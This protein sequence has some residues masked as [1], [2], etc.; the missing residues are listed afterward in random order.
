MAGIRAWKTCLHPGCTALTK[1]GTRCAKHAQQHKSR[2]QAER[3]AGEVM[4]AYR[5]ARWMRM[6]TFLR[7]RNPL[8]QRLVNGQQCEQ[9]STILHH[10]VSPRERPDLMFSAENL[11]CVCDEHHPSTAGE[12]DPSRYVPTVTD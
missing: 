12:T 4:K 8:C 2:Q 7:S 10:I 3:N 11:I 9:F 5:T 6:K 1:S